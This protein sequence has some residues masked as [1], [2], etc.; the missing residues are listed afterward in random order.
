MK[1]TISAIAAATLALTLAACS[2]DDVN[3]SDATSEGMLAA[4]LSGITKDDKIAA[5]VPEAIAADGKLV[6]GTN[7]FFAPA[8]F[9]APDGVTPLGYDIDMGNAIG[10]VFGLDVEFQQAEFAAIIPGIGTRYEIGI[11]NFTINADRQDVVDMIKY[12]QAGSSWAVPAGNPNGFDQTQ[13]CGKVVGVQTGTYQEEVLADMNEGQC[14]DDPIQIQSLSEQSAVTLRVAS[15]QVDA[16][17]TDSPVADYAISLNE[18][19]IERIGEVEDS[20]SYGIVTPKD[21]AELTAAIQ[22]ALQKLMD[23]GQLK[24]IFDTWGISEGVA[25]QA[26]LNP[27]S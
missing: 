12:L 13:P 24:A 25:D 23:D 8:E 27:A 15:G 1:R 19:K 5:M 14:K 6:V 16:M 10:K 17:Y 26:V 21:S 18:G 4:D 9:Y 2:N 3:A 22:A 11:A 20:A 7:I